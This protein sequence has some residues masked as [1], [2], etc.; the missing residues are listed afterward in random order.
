MQ[1]DGYTDVFEAS[2]TG[3]DA[4]VHTIE[5]K[6]ADGG[7]HV[8]DSGVFLQGGSFSDSSTDAVPEPSLLALLG[9]GVLGLVL[10]RRMA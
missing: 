8:W 2:I 6:I 3:L 4:G 7:D 5:L 9:I 1:Y 10:R